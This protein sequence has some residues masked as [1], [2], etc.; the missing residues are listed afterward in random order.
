MVQTVKQ[1]I[2]SVPLQKGMEQRTL[3]KKWLDYKFRSSIKLDPNDAK[4][5]SLIALSVN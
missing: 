2:N 3:S 1:D 4:R 5:L